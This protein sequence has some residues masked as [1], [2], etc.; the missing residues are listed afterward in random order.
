VI[1]DE[2]VPVDAEVFVAADFPDASIF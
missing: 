1:V 2:R